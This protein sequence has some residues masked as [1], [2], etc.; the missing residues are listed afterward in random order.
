MFFYSNYRIELESLNDITKVKGQGRNF[1]GVASQLK[2]LVQ[3]LKENVILAEFFLISFLSF[4]NMKQAMYP[5]SR[6]VNTITN[7]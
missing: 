3:T 4:T 7:P 5:R 6:E 2:T 1:T